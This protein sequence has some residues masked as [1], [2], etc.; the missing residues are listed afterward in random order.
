MKSMTRLFFSL[1]I[2]LIITLYVVIIL[3]HII[4][5]YLIIDID[6][7]IGASNFSAE[8]TLI[9]ELDSHISKEKRQL[10]ID[11]IAERNQ[12]IIQ[13]ISKTEIPLHVL[14]EMEHTNIWFDDDDFNYFKA[15]DDNRHYRIIENENNELVKIDNQTDNYTIITLI[16]C[17]ALCCLIWFFGLQRKLVLIE[18]TLINISEG[19]LAART[20]TKKSMRLGRLNDCVN[21]MADK[22][23]Q[24]LGSHKRLTCTIAHE[25]RTPL[26][27]MQMHLELLTLNDTAVNPEHA[28][29]IEDEIYCLEDMVNELLSYAQMERAELTPSLETVAI[30]KLLNKL[31]GKHASECKADINFTASDHTCY[32]TVDVSL[33]TRAVANLI[34]NAEKYGKSKV[35]I[36]LIEQEKQV[37]INVEDDGQGIIEQQK[38]NIF[39]PYYRLE[40]ASNKTG[41]GLGLSIVK[42]IALLHQGNIQVLDSEYGGTKFSLILPK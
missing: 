31:C 13:P 15:F 25:L 2:R 22:I 1:Y 12:M 42:E 30:D 4:G 18:S 19:N 26:F 27:R 23:E 20:Y 32:L 34:T 10:L 37:I 38:K 35:F 36:S 14:Q 8:I 16:I 41:F 21:T 3:S 33:I 5:T 9:E 7:V 40:E 29:G 17:V 6:N 28:Q 11:M 24:L 39:E